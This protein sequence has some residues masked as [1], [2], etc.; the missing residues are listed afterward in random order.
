MRDHSGKPASSVTHG[1]ARLI[2]GSRLVALLFGALGVA[3]LVAAWKLP[4]GIGNLPGPGFFPAVLGSL[5][6]GFA[7]LLGLERPRAENQHHQ[8]ASPAQTWLLP[9]SAT[10]LLAIFV[11]TWELAPFLLRTPLLVLALMRLSGASWRNTKIAMVL[12]PLALYAI[13]QLGLRV[14]LG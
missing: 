7:L 14:D 1:A 3:I 13:F 6:L 12:F 5:I 4:A 8:P 9:A 2:T 10:L 11:F